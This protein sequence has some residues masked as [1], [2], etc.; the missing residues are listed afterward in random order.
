MSFSGCWIT[1]GS[2]FLGVSTLTNTDG[3]DGLLG[4]TSLIAVTLKLYSLP[5]CRF[6]IVYVV[7]VMVKISLTTFQVRNS[8]LS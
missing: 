6:V 8:S 2:F 4:P 7:S 3:S 5:F 1:G